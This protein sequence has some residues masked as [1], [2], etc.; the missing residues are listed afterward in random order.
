MC[1]FVMRKQYYKYNRDLS[2][3][4]FVAQDPHQKHAESNNNNTEKSINRSNTKKSSTIINA[5][6]R[7]TW[8]N[9]KTICLI[10]NFAT[11]WISCFCYLKKGTSIHCM[12]TSALCDYLD[13][14]KL[15]GMRRRGYLTC[16][17]KCIFKPNSRG[18]REAILFMTQGLH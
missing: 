17:S 13:T 18:P 16:A 8:L 1:F 6:L 14:L 12:M 7:S 4:V 11:L 2:C 9:E 5:S 10:R 15:N 3:A